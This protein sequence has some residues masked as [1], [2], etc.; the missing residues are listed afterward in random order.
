M[1]WN[2]T[3]SYGHPR[4]RGVDEPDTWDLDGA[5]TVFCV[6][7]YLSMDDW[8]LTCRAFG[9]DMH[10]LTAT[11]IDDAKAEAVDLVRQRYREFI[12]A[13]GAFLE[14]AP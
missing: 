4:R 12:K 14:E 13:W 7:R 8:F 5:P 10:K 11:E 1:R 9:L 3:T 6:H 2:D